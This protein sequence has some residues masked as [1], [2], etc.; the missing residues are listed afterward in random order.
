MPWL[1][2]IWL[3]ALVPWLGLSAWLFWGQRRRVRVPFLELWKVPATLAVRRSEPR[4]QVPAIGVLLALA[5]LLLASLA[6]ARP[7]VFRI[8]MPVNAAFTLIV[9]HGITMSA[10]SQDKTRF[11]E[12]FDRL[13]T[14][15]GH[16]FDN[17]WVDL[18]PVPG[19]GVQRV[20]LRDAADQ[21]A[22]LAATALDTRDAVRDETARRTA[23]SE[24]PVVVLSDCQLA[25][26]K[27]S[28]IELGPMTPVHDVAIAL[29]AA[30][31]TP[32]P[33]VMVRLRNQSPLQSAQLLVSS[34][35]A[36]SQQQ[37][38]LPARGQTADYF[39]SLPHLAQTIEATLE[40]DDDQPA[41]NRAWLV[42]QRSWPRVVIRASLVP[43]LQRVVEIYQKTRPPADDSS[44]LQITT[45][46]SET[47]SAGPAIIVPRADSELSITAPFEVTEHPVTE[48]VNWS[49]LSGKIRAAGK[50]PDGWIPLLRS[51]PTVLLAA[52]P[53][54]PRQLWVGFDSTQWPRTP[55]FVIF[56]TGAIDW[57]G[58]GAG[59][60]YAADSLDHW[61]A[62]WAPTESAAG[63]APGTWPGIYRRHD[64]AIR[65]FNAPDVIGQVRDGA[66]ATARLSALNP[67]ASGADASNLLI[68]LSMF[69]MLLACWFWKRPD[70]AAQLARVSRMRATVE[71]A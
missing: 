25:D 65:A 55:D 21:I 66:D 38:R 12:A 71:P 37:V 10:R 50:P 1:S 4:I 3:L 26:D 56:W 58:Q 27:A 61:S 35:D 53:D 31:A 41:D 69:L 8:G 54:P 32:T 39:V 52:R 48:H 49:T 59:E 22:H 23:K 63:H 36:K 46:V 62:R 42:R 51:G 18:A 28:V 24:R 15:L 34:G 60:S 13:K 68:V 2:P 57:A 19:D 70:R 64:G 30:R 29:V 5:G 44:L 6:M 17:A 20:R 7:S 47:P 43:E 40:V 11:Q 45:E 67:A 14:S 33:Q 9:D 16:K